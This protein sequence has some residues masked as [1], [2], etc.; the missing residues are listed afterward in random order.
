L[1]VIVRIASAILALM[2]ASIPSANSVSSRSSCGPIECSA[3]CAASSS[4][5]IRPPRK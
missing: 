3:C 5:D 2:I 4:S 1:T